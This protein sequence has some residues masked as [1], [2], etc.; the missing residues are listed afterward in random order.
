MA[1]FMHWFSFTMTMN[2]RRL[3][4]QS[5]VSCTGLSVW[6]V[7]VCPSILPIFG[8]CG[9]KH[10]GT[11]E[12]G[13]GIGKKE[14]LLEE[15]GEGTIE[16]MRTIKRAVDPSNILN[17]GKVWHLGFCSWQVLIISSSILTKSVRNIQQKIFKP[18]RPQHRAFPCAWNNIYIFAY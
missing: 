4:M 12:H 18:E 17:P 7:H 11:G 10:I 2:W 3:V 14:Y 13:V 15:L 16:L 1:T 8:S 6:M 5:I 9:Y